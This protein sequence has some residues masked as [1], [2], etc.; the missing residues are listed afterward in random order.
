M[1][2]QVVVGT[3]C[4]GEGGHTQQGTWELHTSRL[5]LARAHFLEKQAPDCPTAA[6]DAVIFVSDPVVPAHG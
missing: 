3:L 1:A 4:A 6:H 5:T 2:T